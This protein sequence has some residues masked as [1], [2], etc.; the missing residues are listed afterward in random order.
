[1]KLYELSNNYQNL[2]EIMDNPEIPKEEIEKAINEIED[3]FNDKAEN[4]CKVIKSI[5]LEAKAIK[6]EEKRLATR[7]ITLENRVKNLKYYLDAE[8]KATGIKK[9]KG[10]IF[11]LSIQ[12]NVPSVEINN[13]EVIPLE[14]FIIQEPMINKKGIMDKLK[15]GEVIPGACLKQTESIRIR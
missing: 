4:I 3:K 2:L 5:E 14:Y 11:T 8:M 10:D 7:R 13:L 6:E 9:I 12:K 1:M 15:S